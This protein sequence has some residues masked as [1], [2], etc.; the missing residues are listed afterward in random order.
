MKKTVLSGLVILLAISVTACGKNE[1]NND[2]LEKETN[3]SVDYSKID[4]KSQTLYG[5]VKSIVGNEIE[6]ELAKNPGVSIDGVEKEEEGK[7]EV[8]GEIPAATMTPATEAT[9]EQKVEL[10]EIEKNKPLVE[11]DFTGELKTI[12]IPSGVDIN[13]LSGKSSTGLDAM[14]EGTYLRLIV[15]D[16]KSENPKIVAVDVIS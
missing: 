4:E 2:V 9:D 13:V 16:N 11:L 8:K 5:K 7:E 3:N 10:G 15:D 6:F 12:V 14:K 1:A